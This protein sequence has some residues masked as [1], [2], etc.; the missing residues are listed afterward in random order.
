MSLSTLYEYWSTVF[1]TTMTSSGGTILLL[2]V[3]PMI[4]IVYA[5]YYY[6][7]VVEKPRIFYRKQAPPT[8][9]GLK[10]ERI[11]ARC[12][13]IQ[14]PY[15]PTFWCSNAHLQVVVLLFRRIF[16]S[17]QKPSF[18]ELLT[19]DDGGCTALDWHMPVRESSYNHTNDELRAIYRVPSTNA[20]F[21][22]PNRKVSVKMKTST[23]SCF[24]IR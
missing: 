23:S 10:L 2:M 17:T 13:T 19:H 22:D 8:H 4:G 5:M 7:Y 16:V 9:G 20:L 1:S 15:F 18:R 12:Q 24:C 6:S 11:L 14:R 3:M 21:H